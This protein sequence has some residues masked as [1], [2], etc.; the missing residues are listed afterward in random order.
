MDGGGGE[1]KMT[2]V[3]YNPRPVCSSSYCTLLNFISFNEIV[4]DHD[5]EEVMHAL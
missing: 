5:L 4:A 1:K 3:D 2:S